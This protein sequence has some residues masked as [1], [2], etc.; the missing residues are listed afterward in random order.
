WSGATTDTDRLVA[1]GA[2]D[3]YRT[4]FGRL[5]DKG[6][7]RNHL[8]FAVASIELE[9]IVDGHA[10]WR[11]SL[12]PD[13]LHTS[14][15]GEFTHKRRAQGAT[16]QGRGFAEVHTQGSRLIT[17]NF[18]TDLFARSQARD[19]YTLWIKHRACLGQGQ[20]LIRCCHQ[21][22]V[23]HATAVFQTHINTRGVTQSRNS[24]GHNRDHHGVG[25]TEQQLA[26]G[27]A[28]NS[29]SRVFLAF[30]FVEVFQGHKGNRRVQT[31]TVKAEALHG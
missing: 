16:D 2:H 5:A 31:T 14:L 26:H 29:L 13:T 22:I 4:L 25:Q 7:Q 28:G 8:A 27:L 18:Q 3:R 23:P 6:R 11:I 21:G 12:Y 17:V 20:Q 9:H 10:I 24:G 15:V 19:T 30:T 1:V